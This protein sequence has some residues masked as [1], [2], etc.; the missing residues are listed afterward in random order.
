MQSYNNLNDKIRQN[1]KSINNNLYLKSIFNN[2][3][4]QRFIN[5]VKTNEFSPF[6]KQKLIKQQNL[7]RSYS[8]SFFNNNDD[9]LNNFKTPIEITSQS[10]KF[11][12]FD[13][14]KIKL[15]V[16]NN[17]YNSNNLFNLNQTKQV[18]NLN[19]NNIS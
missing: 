19:K 7:L 14:N 11:K 17:Q 4:F 3:Q 8:M 12:N 15:N 2:Q 13:K 16:K 10:N 6:K 9:Y 18:S 1:F 5:S